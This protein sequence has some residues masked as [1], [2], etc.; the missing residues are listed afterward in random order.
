MKKPEHSFKKALATIAFITLFVSGGASLGV[1]YFTHIKESQRADP[2]FL[3]KYINQKGDLPSYY[4]EEVLGLCVDKSVSIH[5]FN[6]TTG[7][8]K[9]LDNPLIKSAEVKKLLPDSCQVVYELY[10]PVALLK[11][12][13]NAAIDR[14]GRIIP[15]HP[16]YLA[17]GLP[18]VVVGEIAE[19]EWGKKLKLPRV[20]LALKVLK[21][22]P[23]QELEKV[24]VS[25]V[26]QPSYGQR[27]LVVILDDAILRMD[28]DYWEEGLR[29]FSMMRSLLDGNA[30]AVID[31]RIPH[32]ALVASGIESKKEF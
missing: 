9:L 31:L 19:P 11:D 27:E 16:F 32:I 1:L 24:D 10:Q 18:S 29:N 2:A 22:I 8:K 17:E 12:W 4:I 23:L 30:K 26:D 25:R 28:P 14:D 6:S 20:H 21:S 15:F 13:E 3:L 5:E 7:K